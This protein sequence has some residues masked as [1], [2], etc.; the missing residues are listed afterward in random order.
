MRRIL[1]RPERRYAYRSKW[2]T[3]YDI[4]KEIVIQVVYRWV[5]TGLGNSVQLVT[6]VRLG[7]LKSATQCASIDPHYARASHVACVGL[8]HGEIAETIE[9]GD[10]I[11]YE[12]D[13]CS[14]IL[15]VEICNCNEYQTAKGDSSTIFERRLLKVH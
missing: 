15:G 11:Y 4:A 13:P 7:E 6:I 1:W 2:V 10:G 3:G 14:A 8:Q 5:M 9:A 12:L